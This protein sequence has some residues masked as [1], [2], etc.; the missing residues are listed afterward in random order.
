MTAIV[1]VMGGNDR[2][3]EWKLLH[4]LYVVGCVRIE[5]HFRGSGS[6]CSRIVLKLPLKCG[7]QAT[8]RNL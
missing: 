4:T 5:Q 7:F 1:V 8:T 3:Q 6:M 2:E